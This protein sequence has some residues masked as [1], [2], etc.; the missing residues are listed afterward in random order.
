MAN[1]EAQKVTPLLNSK[2]YNPDL[3]LDTMRSELGLKNDAQL[4]YRIGISAPSLSK[5]RKRR[6][7]VTALMLLA[8]HDVDSHLYP[9]ARIRK[10]MGGRETS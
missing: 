6:Q 7:P 2:T 4:A 10:L 9:V 3:L 5:L 8:I 1:A